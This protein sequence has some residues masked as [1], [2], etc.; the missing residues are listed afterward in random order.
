MSGNQAKAFEG[1][2]RIL[3]DFSDIKIVFKIITKMKEKIN[4]HTKSTPKGISK[5]HL[6]S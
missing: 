2:K 1:F 3:L 4:L 5:R 6:Y